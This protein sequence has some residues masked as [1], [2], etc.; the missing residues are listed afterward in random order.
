MYQSPET[1]IENR[2]KAQISRKERRAYA[3]EHIAPLLAK[4]G[5]V[6][7]STLAKMLKTNPNK[8]GASV[9]DSPSLYRVSHEIVTRRLNGR[10]NSQYMTFVELTEQ[11]M[12]C[13]CDY[14]GIPRPEPTTKEFEEVV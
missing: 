5:I 8:V 4:W 7:L 6:T 9:K 13:F 1:E 10:P 2:D 14:K 11:G 12:V 3:A